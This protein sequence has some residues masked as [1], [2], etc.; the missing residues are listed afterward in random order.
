MTWLLAEPAERLA[1]WAET[2]GVWLRSEG[3]DLSDPRYLRDR[4]PRTRLGRLLPT[5]IPQLIE[6]GMAAFEHGGVRI[7]YSD[8]T[9]LETQGIDAFESVV[10]WAPFTVELETSGWLG[11]EGFKYYHRFYSGSQ[12][13]HPERL[14]CFVRRANIIYRLDA[15]TFALIEA[16]DGFNALPPEAKVSPD[17]FIRFAGVKGLAEGVGAQLDNYLANERVLV[18]SRVGL[19][20]IVEE[21][22]RISFAPKIDGAPPEAMQQAFFAL[23]DVDA[24][25]ALDSPEGGRVRV[26]LDETQREVLRRMQRVRHLK[27][28]DRAEVLRNPH[29][30]FD[31]IVEAV[32]IDLGVFGPR[33]KGIGDF[34]FVAQPYLQRSG[35]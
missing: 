3:A 5:L 32:D 1:L 23:D 6:L 21:E 26:V 10:P 31:G 33:V 24:V 30:V 16:I 11:G 20:L 19:D 4:T 13:V 25:Y 29:A 28:A 35:S 2:N 17:A 7:S 9:E 27:G 34:P 18:P 12:V 14:G 15:Q 22:G 8:F